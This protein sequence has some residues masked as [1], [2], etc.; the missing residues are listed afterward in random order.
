[1]RP[2]KPTPNELHLRQENDSLKTTICCLRR[3]LEN[4]DRAV[5]RLE[6]LMRERERTETIDELHG[7]IDRLRGRTR[8]WTRKPSAWWRS[9]SSTPRAS[10]IGEAHLKSWALCSIEN[11]FA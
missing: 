4:S 2:P 8:N 3:E 9:S 5:G 10:I 11:T 6:V 7:T 1:M